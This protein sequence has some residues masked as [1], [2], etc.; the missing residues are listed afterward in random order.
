MD[1]KTIARFGSHVDRRG[2]DE[3][4]PWTAHLSRW[5][6]GV[7]EIA[8]QK[9]LAHRV[10]WEL[11]NGVPPPA[12]MCVCHRCDV[13]ACV[14]PDH[15]FLGTHADNVADRHAK[16]RSR[17]GSRP[18]ESSPSAKLTSAQV[19]SL[20]SDRATLGMTHRALASKYRIDAAQVQRILAGKCWTRVRAI[21][22]SKGT[23]P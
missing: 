15:L 10:A 7:T 23:T 3:C 12:D 16:G 18:G 6:Y 14:N 20:R 5:G 4:W 19:A 11:S 2:P 9:K 22:E 13:P 1:E 21:L 17:G 8:G